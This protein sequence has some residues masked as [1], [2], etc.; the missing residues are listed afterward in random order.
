[1]RHEKV[2]IIFQ[3]AVQ[4][5]AESGFDQAKMDDIANVAGVAKG[6]IYYHFKSKEE[7]F[8]ALMDEGIESLIDCVKR[9][10]SLYS[11]PIE[12]LNALIHAQIQFF[13][14]NQKLAK[15]LLSE[16]FG[17]KERQQLFR[18]RIREYMQLIEQIL[19]DGKESG[20]LSV[21]HSHE[22]ASAIFGA[23]S[24]LVL[25]KIY[26]F[27]GKELEIEDDS[28]TVMV[29]TVRHLLFNSLMNSNQN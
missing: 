20:E 8:S 26:S 5:F 19:Q 29:E 13:I 25:H 10:V 9:N 6:T 23:A 22:L 11:N 1:M 24:I 4:V 17:T 16:V 3:A 7:L 15:L 28:V 21:I 18:K 12:R 27:E 2:D 14:E